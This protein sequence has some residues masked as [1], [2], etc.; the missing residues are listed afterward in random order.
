MEWRGKYPGLHFT[1]ANNIL[2]GSP[3]GMA[4]LVKP[5]KQEAQTEG[6]DR[7]LPA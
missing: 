2:E 4:L 6:V 3:A 5:D 7:S 1:D